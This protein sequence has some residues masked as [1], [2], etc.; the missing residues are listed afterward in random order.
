MPR[1]GSQRH[2]PLE[3]LV[4]FQNYDYTGY[5]RTTSPA[6]EHNK[7]N[8]PKLEANLNGPEEGRAK[9]VWTLI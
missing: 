4:T 7:A 3:F 9:G 2:G 1:E 6:L 5:E 8:A